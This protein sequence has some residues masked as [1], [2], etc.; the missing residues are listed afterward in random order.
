MFKYISKITSLL[1]S[2]WLIDTLQRDK[3]YAANGPDRQEL[4]QELT[5][6]V[7]LH[8]FLCFVWVFFCPKN[9]W[10]PKDSIQ[11]QKKMNYH[12]LSQSSNRL[13]YQ[14]SDLKYLKRWG[15]LNFLRFICRLFFYDKCNLTSENKYISKTARRRES[16]AEKGK[17]LEERSCP[18]PLC[19]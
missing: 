19:N 1:M 7:C 18:P 9:S 17:A 3:T 13:I 5:V 6:E 12:C 10:N 11:L 4:N 16:K 15:N 2:I 14:L 8:M